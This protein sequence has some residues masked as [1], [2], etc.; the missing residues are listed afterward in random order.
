MSKE[1][2][3]LKIVGIGGGTGLPILLSGLS[4]LPDLCRHE[5]ED[6]QIDL[7][8]VV[9]VADDG[10]SSGMLRRS[11]GIPALGDL[12]NCLASL[13]RP[14]SSWTRVFQHRFSTG[15]GLKGH[16]AG[17]LILAALHQQTGSLKRALEQASELLQPRGCVFPVTERLISLCA[18]LQD[19]TVV[20]GETEIPQAAQAIKRVWLDPPDSPACRGVLRAI[21]SADLIVLGPGS[22][23]TSIIPNL[24][25]PAVA[26]SI[27]KS[28]ALKVFICNLM[29]QPGE[30]DTFTVSDH[31]RL[32][33]SYLG[34]SVDVCIINSTPIRTDQAWPHFATGSEPVQWNEEELEEM[35]TV[36]MIADLL[37]DSPFTNRHDPLK[38]GRLILFLARR[39]VTCQLKRET[40]ESWV[41]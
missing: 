31:L 23:Y 25:V 36:P 9:T 19:G 12:R 10:G 7:A 8:A 16:T 27:C 20:W 3:I 11:L 28:Q 41:A 38:L 37:P 22:L 30:T 32:L 21:A 15:A 4:D 5:L 34:R 2:A 40:E 14:N 29:T 18:E 24:L 13:A 17:N 6:S 1:K 33:A 35:G 26:D 39:A